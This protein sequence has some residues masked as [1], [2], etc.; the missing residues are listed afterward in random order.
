MTVTFT[1]AAE[2]DTRWRRESA[3]R[4]GFGDLVLVA[5][6][7]F[8]ALAIALTYAGRFAAFK[9]SEHA[10]S[11]API[12]LSAVDRPELLEPGLAAV[13]P[14]AGDRQFAAR[15]WFQ[16]LTAE[17]ASGHRLPNVGAAAHATAAAE[18]IQRNPR[19]D[20]FPR[21]LAAAR[22]AEAAAGRPA[23]ETLPLFTAADLAAMKPSFV[24]RTRAQFR[25]Q[26]LLWSILYLLGFH[27]VAL[28]WRMRAIDGDRLLLAAAHL[29]TGLGLVMLLSRPDP[30]RDVPLFVRYS[31]GVLLGLGLL[32][33]FSTIDFG[34][35]AFLELSYVPLVGAIGLCALLILFGGGPGRSGAKVNLGPVQPI[36]AIRLLLVFF[37]AGY[38]ARRWELV[39]GVRSRAI[40]SLRLPAWMNIPRGEYVLPVLAGV[41]VALALFAVQKD[42]GPCAV[43]F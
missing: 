39:R 21:R 33:V 20:V 17:R 7:C 6:S 15:D 24:V 36:E 18:A 28:V 25:D 30:L 43:S 11:D 40:R 10:R 31:E 41:A 8:V 16:F 38:F 27:M 9:R 13:F 22:D 1:P 32:I 42:L 29:I 3:A 2:R 12:D 19:L 14:D 34:T 23:P 26:L 5:T 4:F 35:A 37:L